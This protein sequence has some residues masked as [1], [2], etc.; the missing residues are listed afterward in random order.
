M[1]AILPVKTFTFTS[2]LDN[3]YHVLDTQS[4]HTV[5]YMNTACVN[6]RMR[7]VQA[8]KCRPTVVYVGG[9]AHTPG[10]CELAAAAAAAA[11]VAH[12]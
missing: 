5:K 12:R 6:V 10:G 2:V 4:G 3:V 8:L 9:S 11:A 1:R 7:M